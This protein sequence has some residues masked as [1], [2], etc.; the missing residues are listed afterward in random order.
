M[1]NTP[2]CSSPQLNV[3]SCL[4]GHL[5]R[6]AEA[7]TK[8]PASV[9][10]LSSSTHTTIIYSSR[11][12]QALT[13]WG[14]HLLS[15]AAKQA[16]FYVLP[17][18]FSAQQPFLILLDV[19]SCLCFFL[20]QSIPVAFCVFRIK[21]KVIVEISKILYFISTSPSNLSLSHPL[22]APCW[23]PCASHQLIYA[24]QPLHYRVLQL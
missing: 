19:W 5:P 1:V 6:L 16:W 3:P 24:P 22:P 10:E 2:D 14:C 13:A 20:T 9:S 15:G 8:P 11:T 12:Q 23:I 7:H 17:S 18:A 4:W 21:V